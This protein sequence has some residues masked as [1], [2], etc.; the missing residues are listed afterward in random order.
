MNING[1]WAY[2]KF[3]FVGEG[4]GVGGADKNNENI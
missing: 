3:Y 1:A 2:P 4:G